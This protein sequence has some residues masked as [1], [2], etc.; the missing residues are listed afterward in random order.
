MFFLK[1]TAWTFLTFKIRVCSQLSFTYDIIKHKFFK[2][3]FADVH[4]TPQMCKIQLLR[5]CFLLVIGFQM[6]EFLQKHL[7]I[8]ITSSIHLA[9]VAIRMLTEAFL[10]CSRQAMRIAVNPLYFMMPATVGC[11]YAFMLPVST[12]PNSIAFASG[13]LLVKDM[14]RCSPV[15]ET[16]NDPR[17]P[18][19]ILCLCS[20]VIRQK[21]ALWWTFWAFWPFPSPWTRGVSPCLTWALIQNGHI[22]W[23]SRHLLIMYT[24]LSRQSMLPTNILFKKGKTDSSDLLSLQRCL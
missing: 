23:I 13:H 11:S 24:C 10:I 22:R 9:V 17:L 14:V 19:L 6:M 1:A 12:P 2:V 18:K 3:E 5:Y 4:V 16:N 8:L 15:P 20:L 21:L 7:L